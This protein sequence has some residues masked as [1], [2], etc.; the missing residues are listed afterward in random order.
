METCA[1][2]NGDGDAMITNFNIFLFSI[3]V[4]FDRNFNLMSSGVPTVAVG[5]H[6]RWPC[7]SWNII[8][9]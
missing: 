5:L 9:I 6:I 4:L 1:G 2:D 3:N 8:S 7:L